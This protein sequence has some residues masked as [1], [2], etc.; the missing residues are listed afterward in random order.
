MTGNEV[1][2]RALRDHGVDHVFFLMGGPMIDAENAC[3]DA[4]IRMVDVR[5]E[6][7][8]AMMANAYSRVLCRPSV[9]MAASGPGTTNLATGVAH[10]FVDCAPVIALGGS[11]PVSQYGMG[12]FQEMD[13]LSMMRPVTRWAERAYD[14]RR[15]PE[16]VAA[17]F[18][19][20]FSGRPGPVY[21]DLPGDVLYRQVE[22]AEVRWARA[23]LQRRR[24]LGDPALVDR[25]V[26][27]LERAE[28]PALVCGSGVLWSEAS[29]QLQAWV[30]RSGIPFWTTPQGRG[31]IPEDHP[32][33]FLSARATAFREADLVFVIGTRL[34]YVIDY[35]RPPRIA[36]GARLVQVDIDPEELGR[37]RDV[38]VGIVGDA[39]AVLQQLLEA[40]G[41]R[42]RGRFDRWV[43]HLSELNEEKRLDAERAMA[44]GQLPIH[45][46]RLCREVRE[47]LDRDAILCVDGQEILNYGR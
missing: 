45:P 31:V 7:A 26:G 14:A 25:A 22:P 35:G 18:R 46:L 20:A 12:A 38:D 37:T 34:N 39:R 41:G 42:L 43:S 24:P 8:A 28:R 40:V 27:L 23:D 10:A 3:Q 44:T 5:H 16:L 47:F 13:Q 30:D 17:A 33:C 36:E 11:S 32:L 15:I 9:C 4:G 2:A 19:H 1:L 21:L 6:Q 29:E